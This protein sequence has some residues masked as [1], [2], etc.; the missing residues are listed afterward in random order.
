MVVM[1]VVV[2]QLVF[3]L[4]KFLFDCMECF[5]DDLRYFRGYRILR[6]CSARDTARCS[7]L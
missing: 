1:V 2:E 3:P 4:V 7:R 5:A 6:S